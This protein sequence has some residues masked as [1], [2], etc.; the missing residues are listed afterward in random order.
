MKWSSPSGGVYVS[1]KERKTFIFS[2]DR[3]TKHL[4][5]EGEEGYAIGCNGSYGPVFSGGG[6]DICTSSN[7]GSDNGSL[8]LFGNSY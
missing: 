1:D 2:I 6:N 3:R 7:F 5:K 4:L 8:S